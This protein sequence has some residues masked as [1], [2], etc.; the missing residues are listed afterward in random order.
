MDLSQAIHIVGSEVHLDGRSDKDVLDRV[1]DSPDLTTTTKALRPAVG[2]HGGTILRPFQALHQL[3]IATKAHYQDD[4][5]DR[6]VQWGL[7]R[8]LGLFEF[9]DRGHRLPGL[10]VSEAGQRISGNQRRVTS[11]EMGIGF[12]TF[13]AIRWFQQVVGDATP[14]SVV[15]VDVALDERYVFAAGSRYAVRAGGSRRP[16]YLVIANDPA[17]R[18]HYR[19]RVLECKGTSRAWYA[20]WQLMSAVQQLD[21]ITVDG[22]APAGLAVS[23]ITANEGVSYLAVD[24]EGD[25]EDSYEVNSNTIQRGAS[26][27]LPDED[28]ADVSPTD[29]TNAS[30]RA[31]WATLADFGGNLEALERWAPAVMR[32]RLDRQPR[33][34]FSFDTPF[35]TARGTSVTFGFGGEQLQVNYAID[36]TIDQQITHDAPEAIIEAQ[37]SFAQRLTASRI[38]VQQPETQTLY[39]ATPDGS[40]FSLSPG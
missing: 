22:R 13:L 39:S 8:Y 16:D 31:S 4:L 11:E 14:M 28:V 20:I 34:R 1:A 24:P 29:L 9:V 26:F 27:Q 33:D 10:G 12:G 6:Y 5:F 36:E 25:E 30:V 18:S 23:T 3:S 15:D 7:L 40:I 37:I 2:L 17:V 21:G 32:R 38:Y 19:V 35:G